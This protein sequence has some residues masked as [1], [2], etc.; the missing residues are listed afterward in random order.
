M[1][2]IEAYLH[3]FDN[4]PLKGGLSEGAQSLGVL[5]NDTVIRCHLNRQRTHVGSHLYKENH[6]S[7]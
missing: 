3:L 6:Y 2:L 5:T 1:G 4:S 7:L